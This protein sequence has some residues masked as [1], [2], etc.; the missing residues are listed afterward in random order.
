MRGFP[1]KVAWI[2]A[3]HVC[4][5]HSLGCAGA[6]NQV[7]AHPEWPGAQQEAG[8]SGPG[9]CALTPRD[10]GPVAQIAPEG[11]PGERLIVSGVVCLP[12]GETPAEGYVLY[13]YHTDVNGVYPPAQDA[14]R[15]IRRHG[16]LHAWMKLG[17]DGRYEFRTIRPAA[18]PRET[19]PAHIH[20]IV[21]G[22]GYPERYIDD[23]VF[24]DDPLLTERERR[25][26]RGVGGEGAAL[27]PERGKD[28]ALRATRDIVLPTRIIQGEE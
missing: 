26:L 7:E 21:G 17:E 20:A 12:D 1:L 6:E 13:V 5:G 27:R 28:G 22:P 9:A 16:R 23:Y 14:P 4:A 3:L 8:W 11:E 2:A 10:A 25:H 15:A 24:E 19:I 18:Y